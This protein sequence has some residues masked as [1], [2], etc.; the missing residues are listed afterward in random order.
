M[1]LFR[2]SPVFKELKKLETSVSKGKLWSLCNGQV[3]KMLM[4]SPQVWMSKEEN[5]A[6]KE[7]EEQI[8]KTGDAFAVDMLAA[9][10]LQGLPLVGMLAGFSNPVYYHRIMKYV[11]MKYRKRY[12]L[13]KAGT[14]I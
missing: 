5:I 14:D 4:E 8:R 1:S 2:Q 10:F 3:D 9:K 7:L 12:L 13:Q 11:E 6:R